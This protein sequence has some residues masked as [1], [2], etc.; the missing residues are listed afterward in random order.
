MPGRVWNGGSGRSS[1]GNT[2]PSQGA[3]RSW[4]G[5]L[6]PAPSK[7]AQARTSQKPCSG[8]VTSTPSGALAQISPSKPGAHVVRVDP[9][10]Y[11]KLRASPKDPWRAEPSLGWERW[12]TC[13]SRQI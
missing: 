2:L 11:W 6:V 8:C 7:D 9:V 5:S 3:R 10:R 4:V 1:G 13:P 12:G